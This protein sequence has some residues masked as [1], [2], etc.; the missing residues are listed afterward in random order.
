MAAL[1]A[2]QGAPGLEEIMAELNDSQVHPA[3]AESLGFSWKEE[4]E[5][6]GGIEG[7]GVTED[8][9]EVHEVS[10]VPP[11]GSAD[12]ECR[13]CRCGWEVGPLLHPCK[14]SGSIR[15]VHAEC[16]I[17]WLERTLASSCELCRHKFL[18]S[19]MYSVHAPGR[20]SSFEFLLGLATLGAQKTVFLARCLPTPTA[21]AC[22]IARCA[23]RRGAA[24][25]SHS[26]GLTKI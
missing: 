3:E 13:I 4:E 23:R 26:T 11:H 22:V 2:Q 1:G 17:R 25:L 20:L 9:E 18:F 19:P 10:H 6:E 7:G 24:A 12:D 15:Y 8:E 16:Q 5:P 14:C 21:S